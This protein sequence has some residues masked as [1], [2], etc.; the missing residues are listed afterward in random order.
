M[1]MARWPSGPRRVT[2]A[3]AYLSQSGFSS[4]YAGRGSNP[5]LVNFFTFLRMDPLSSNK[6]PDG[7][8][9]RNRTRMDY[10]IYLKLV[11]YANVHPDNDGDI[12][13]RHFTIGFTPRAA[14]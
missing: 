10:E 1:V 14:R 12:S 8:S 2:Q 13:R 3:K 11:L 4:A 9:M 7:P 6:L 5:L